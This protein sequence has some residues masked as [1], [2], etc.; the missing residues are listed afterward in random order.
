MYRLAFRRGVSFDWATKNP[1]LKEG[2]PGLETDTH[3]YKLGDGS[4]RWNDLPYYLN[5]DLM[6]DYIDEAIANSPSG[7]VTQE[8]LQQHVD[9]LT[10][11]P[12]YDDGPSL[13]LLYENAKV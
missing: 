9:S 5:E 4:T 2:E 8:E 12:V 7:D 10:P 6:I 1:I 13:L 3:K 11:H